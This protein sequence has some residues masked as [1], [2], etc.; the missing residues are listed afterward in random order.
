MYSHSSGYEKLLLTFSIGL[1]G[2][3]SMYYHKYCTFRPY[4]SLLSNGH[5]PICET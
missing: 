4:Q 1:R 3:S 5:L 2:Y